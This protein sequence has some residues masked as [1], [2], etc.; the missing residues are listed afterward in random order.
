MPIRSWHLDSLRDFGK[1]PFRIYLNRMDS[2]SIGRW[3]Y[4]FKGDCTLWRANCLQISDRTTSLNN[5]FNIVH[6]TKSM[7]LLIIYGLYI[8]HY[9]YWDF[10][11]MCLSELCM[12]AALLLL[13]LFCFV[14][15]LVYLGLSCELTLSGLHSQLQ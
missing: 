8:M 9:H 14:L 13:F 2:I 12:I 15:F 6:L 3:L 10:L 4:P 1:Y 7:F 11:V 5:S